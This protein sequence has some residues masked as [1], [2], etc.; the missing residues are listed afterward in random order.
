MTSFRWR[1]AGLAALMSGLVL[2]VFGA[3]AWGMLYQDRV[4]SL[5]EE[6]KAFGYVIGGR[7]GRNIEGKKVDESL[8][9]SFGPD[10]Q[11]RLKIIDGQKSVL[12]EVQWPHELKP[13]DFL[14]S[15]MIMDPQP[16]LPKAKRNADG[17]FPPE[18]QQTVPRFYTA[19]AD[20]GPMRVGVF[21]NEQIILYLARDLGPVQADVRRL[22]VA[23]L[24]ALPGA[25]LIIALG[26]AFL[27]RKALRPIDVLSGRMETLS[28]QGLDQRL[29]LA[30]ADKEFNRIV[31]AFNDMMARLEKSFHQANRFSA[32]ASHELKT[33]LAVLQ[34]TIQQAR[35]DVADDADAQPHLSEMQE[36]VSRLGQILEGLL[37]LSRADAGKLQLSKQ[38]I[39]VTQWIAPLFED[40]DLMCEAKG[41]TSSCEVDADLV[42][43]GDSV[44]LQQVV[45]NLFVNA[46]KYNQP[47]G[48]VSC[49]VTR[50][51]EGVSIGVYN[52]GPELSAEQVACLFD[53]F[54]QA[55]PAH[56]EGSG[57]GL[58]IA[59]EII[60]AH[61]GTL[62]FERGLEGLYGFVIQLS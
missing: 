11:T 10:D 47:G 56:G 22:G 3:V 54:Y 20:N 1:L 25:L 6:L 19:Q 8:L 13:T 62:D 32:D 39:N 61:G 58:S 55:D 28:A 36:E 37:L 42:V 14:H 60:E 51:E 41:L 48:R 23:F 24:A 33:P 26:S 44:M 59:R 4:R 52:T 5:D 53:R 29:E 40:L 35:A 18:R 27:A 16:I 17:R 34:G 57:L 49:V 12:H 31:G 50:S 7:S 30:D 21:S 46:V 2:L 15:G 43:E 45:T 9:R 38:S